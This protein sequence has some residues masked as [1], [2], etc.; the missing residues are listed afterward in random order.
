MEQW[1]KSWTYKNTCRSNVGETDD[2]ELQGKIMRK[3]MGEK[4][5]MEEPHTAK[6]VL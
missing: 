6:M 2:K 4:K 1:I 5:N 3:H